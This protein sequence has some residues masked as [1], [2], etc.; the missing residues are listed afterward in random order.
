MNI[1]QQECYMPITDV[2]I[3]N[4]SKFILLQNIQI[5]ILLLKVTGS[6]ETYLDN[7]VNYS[8]RK[9]NYL[10]EIVKNSTLRHSL[11][12]EVENIQTFIEIKWKHKL[13]VKTTDVIRSNCP[14]NKKKIMKVPQQVKTRTNITKTVLYIKNVINRIYISQK[15]E[16]DDNSK[17][18]VTKTR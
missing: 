12:K 17:E 2:L 13:S 11:L 7:K 16:T 8:K 9:T 10:E 4:V 15:K 3:E 14:K 5:G 1:Q 18:I 6:K